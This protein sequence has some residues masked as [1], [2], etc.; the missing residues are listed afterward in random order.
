VRLAITWFLVLSLSL[1]SA[2]A[3]A[4][5]KGAS[6]K[7][8]PEKTQQ[9]P[10]AGGDAKAAPP[11]KGEPLP[12]GVLA[13]VN[14]KEIS[15]QDYTAYLFATLGKTRLREFIDRLLT[16]EEGRRL[17]VAITPEEVE[18]RVNAQIE[19]TLRALYQN[20]M[21]KFV[22]SL[23][24]RNL[25]LEEHKL[26]LRQ[27]TAYK[28]LEEKCILKTRKVT[29]EDIRVRFEQTYGEGGVQYEIRHILIAVRPRTPSGDPKPALTDQEARAKAEK[30]LK[31]LQGGA[32]FVQL[33]KAYSDD[34]LTKRNDGRIPQYRKGYRGPEFHEAVT[35][36]TE[37]NRISGVVRSPQGYHIIQLIEKKTTRLEDKREEILNVL[38]TQQPTP[39]ERAT[40]IRS[41]REKAKIEM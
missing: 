10:P 38:N 21:E 13:R 22:E 33:V 39:Q 7:S 26:K 11:G 1:V 4:Q 2:R 36:L 14:G 6:E 25:T 19:S 29:D 16:E 24:R 18:G 17:E 34:E 30:V 5:E 40:F 28:L 15:A 23:A 20:S 31:E 41:L 35:R 12:A 3:P 8:A 27:E 9:A 37:D 32:D